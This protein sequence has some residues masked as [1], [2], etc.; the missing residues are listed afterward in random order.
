VSTNVLAQD[1]RGLSRLFQLHRLSF[2]PPV[3]KTMGTGI[4]SEETISGTVLF[5]ALC[6]EPSPGF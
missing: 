2:G 6:G 5:G 4:V 3:A 1:G